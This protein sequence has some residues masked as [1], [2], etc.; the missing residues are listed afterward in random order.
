M[1]LRLVKAVPE[2][3]VSAMRGAQVHQIRVIAIFLDE[4]YC[5]CRVRYHVPL[6]QV[7]TRIDQLDVPEQERATR[8]GVRCSA[9]SGT[10]GH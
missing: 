6:C 7:E 4:R 3:D 2:D 10:L 1:C 9:V 5:N 8:F